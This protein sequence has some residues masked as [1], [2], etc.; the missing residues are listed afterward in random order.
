MRVPMPSVR[1]RIWPGLSGVP[2][3]YLIV[4]E[5][6]EASPDLPQLEVLADVLDVPV[7]HFLG[8]HLLAADKSTR[9]IE[10]EYL[11]LR[12]RIVGAM[13]RQQREALG[14][15]TGELAAK[16]Q[17]SPDDLSQYEVGRSIAMPVLERIADGLG[18]SIED[19]LPEAI[20]QQQVESHAHIEAYMDHDEEVRDFVSQRGSEMFIRIAM[21]LSDLSGDQLREIAIQLTEI[22]H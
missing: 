2:I 15:S 21:M 14:L 5:M 12:R 13:L 22:T 10:S 1:W 8:T 17:I 3:E 9:S 11:R 18:M 4:W 20:T 6:G 19:L 16:L 7:T